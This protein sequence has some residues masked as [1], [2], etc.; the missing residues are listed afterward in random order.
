M[1]M[2]ETESNLK[3]SFEYHRFNVSFTSSFYSYSYF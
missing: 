3:Q 2:E 1:K